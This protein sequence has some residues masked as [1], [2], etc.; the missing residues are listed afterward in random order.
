MELYLA[1]PMTGLPGYNYRAFNAAARKLRKLGHGVFNPAE[2]H[3]GDTTMAFED[4]LRFDLPILIGCE[5]IVVL[6]GWLKSPGAK[7]EFAV[8]MACGLDVFGYLDGELYPFAVSDRRV[9][10]GALLGVRNVLPAL[11]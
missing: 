5:G 11:T 7:L 4:Y 6:P 1:G 3:G 10:L 2:A 8:S 9:E